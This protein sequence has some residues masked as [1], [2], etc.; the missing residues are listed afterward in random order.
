M[1][2]CPISM[3]VP[4]WRRGECT[5]RGE[6][7]RLTRRECDTLACLLIRRNRWTPTAFLVGILWPDPSAEPEYAENI[8]RH[9]VLQ[10]RRKLP[11]LIAGAVGFGHMIDGAPSQSRGLHADHA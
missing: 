10:L 6:A 4:Q 11:G 3:S 5:F 2:H 9:I 8:V 1:R 7:I